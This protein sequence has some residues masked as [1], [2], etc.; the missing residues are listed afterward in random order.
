MLVSSEQRRARA[1]DVLAAFL[2]DHEVGDEVA[3]ERLCRRHAGL[4]AELRALRA[5]FGALQDRLGDAGAADEL[6][7]EAADRLAR[8]RAE[9][10]AR[11]RSWSEAEAEETRRLIARL[12]DGRRRDERFE[13]RG[14]VARGG[15]GV[16]LRAWDQDLRR[17]LAMKVL[18]ED[19]EPAAAGEAP[20]RSLTRFLEEAQVT[21]QLEHP[22]IV[23]VHELGVDSEGRVYFTMPLIRGR[24]FKAVL[25]LVAGGEQGWTRT[26]ALGVVIKVCEAMAY[27][28]SKGVLHRDLKPANVMVG[29]FG[30]VYVMDWGL[31]RVMGRPDTRDLRLRPAPDDP[32]SVVATDRSLAKS[33]TPDSPLLTMDGDVVGTPSYMSP[34]QAEGRIE[35][36]GPRSEVYAIGAILYQLLTGQ[37]PYVAS[38]S[39]IS[40]RTVLGLLLQGPPPDVLEVDPDVAP[41]LAAICR[42]AMERKPLDRYADTLE[43][44]R[45]LE[46][47]LD[48]RPV[49]ARGGDPLYRA[50]LALQRNRGIAATAAAG[51]ATLLVAG[52]LFV[53]GLRRAADDEATARAEAEAALAYTE[54]L[55]DFDSADVLVRQERDLYPA[56]PAR[57][58]AFDAWIARVQ[59]LLSRRA[60]YEDE[61]AA[62]VASASLAPLL[63]DLTTL[64]ERLP[65][66]EERRAAASTVVRRT[67]D[68]HAAAWA[69]AAA[70]V[71]ADPRF[72]G[73]ELEPVPGLV[74]L[75]HHP[76]TGLWE[77]WHV[78]TGERPAPADDGSG[79]L[80][81]TPESG[82][83]LVLLP[84][85][86]FTAGSEPGEPERVPVLEDP[87]EVTL[88]PFFVSKYELTQ[89]QWERCMDTNDSKLRMGHPVPEPLRMPGGEDVVGGLH[90]VE[91]VTW[92]ECTDFARR[93]DLGL[94][95]EDQW[96][97][98]C[99]AGTTGPWCWGEDRASLAGRENVGDASS[100][101]LSRVRGLA[102]W[103]DGYAMHAPV[104]SFAENAFGLYDVHGNVAEWCEGRAPQAGDDRAFRGGSWYHTPDF[105]RSAFRQ[106][107]TPKA[108]N[109]ARGL[110]PA[111][112]A[113]P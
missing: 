22:G 87:R 64:A 5:E 82:V 38:G 6:E 85:G 27:A 42:K 36:M 7:A 92:Y 31:S 3:F 86:T 106:S 51:L 23:P 76:R 44:A 69:R 35:E 18:P 1:E 83:V 17:T 111:R 68:D 62:G 102:D 53:A 105:C 103:A 84:G 39:R 101:G 43:L 56:L 96:E 8:F 37:M 21:G 100:A 88:E 54:R 11:A 34:E 78:A 24:D 9:R 110:R 12:T 41:E 72:A 107:D 67:V 90:P 29:R 97:Y 10:G 50:R 46:R 48:R 112:G 91:R 59:D 79:R 25:E 45:D 65:R 15:M 71:A 94:P 73:F 14:E 113:R 32:P 75:Q 58:P 89:A 61:A 20:G 19:A 66:V 33:Q 40:A 77:F 30:E 109:M 47:F 52:G 26:R 16:I 60:A 98:A 63:A 95:T 81:M 70:E 4:D 104:G 93:V 28:H 55:L 74:P 2:S 49:R 108:G 99:R 80:V 57:I 13:L